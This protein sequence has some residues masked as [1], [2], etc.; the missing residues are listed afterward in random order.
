[1][2]HY[3]VVE[4]LYPNAFYLFWSVFNLL[5]IWSRNG[6]V[7]SWNMLF[8]APGDNGHVYTPLYVCS[9][10]CN[11]GVTRLSTRCTAW[12]S[13][14]S[15]KKQTNK[16]S[17]CQYFVLFMVAPT[18]LTKN[19]YWVPK[20][21]VHKGEKNAKSRLKNAKSD[22]AHVRIDHFIK[23][24]LCGFIVHFITCASLYL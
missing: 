17:L 13:D 4:L 16:L 1:M 7:I 8:W 23:F 12:E 6:W 24:G 20:I 22:N 15:T 19:F 5:L 10:L 18:D 3:F 14:F 11:K 9:L 21:T 2:L